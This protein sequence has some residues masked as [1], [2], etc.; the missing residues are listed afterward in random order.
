MR[1]QVHPRGTGCPQNAGVPI[2][3]N[4]LAAGSAPSRGAD[5][6][7]GSASGNW[8]DAFERRQH[9]LLDAKVRR[10]QAR[11]RQDRT[12]VV[13]SH[14]RDQPPLAADANAVAHAHTAEDGVL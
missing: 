8:F 5:A 12:G 6:A 13:R 10:A 11:Q 1:Q 14:F 9:A 4:E 3:R 7:E 2:V